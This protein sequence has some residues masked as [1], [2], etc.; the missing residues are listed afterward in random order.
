MLHMSILT[1][2]ARPSS[3]IHPE[4]GGCSV[5]QNVGTPSTN[6]AAKPQEPKLHTKSLVFSEFLLEFTAGTNWP[7]LVNLIPSVR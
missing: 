6:D 1:S 7:S 4:D 5:Y 2:I 3:L